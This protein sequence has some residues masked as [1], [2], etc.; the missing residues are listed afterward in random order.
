MVGDE[1]NST[2]SSPISGRDASNNKAAL[3][4]LHGLGDSTDGWAS[5]AEALPNMRPSLGE[6]DMTYVFPPAQMVAITVN[7]GEKM[8]GA[9]AV[10][11]HRCAY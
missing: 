10:L 1:N 4:F 8:S 11:Y 5:L 2:E 9:F 7:G 6:L 3:I